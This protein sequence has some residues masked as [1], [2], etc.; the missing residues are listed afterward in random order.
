MFCLNI[1]REQCQTPSP[2]Y[3]HQTAELERLPDRPGLPLYLGPTTPL[4]LL[5]WIEC[6]DGT[7]QVTASAPGTIFMTLSDDLV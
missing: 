1:G 4:L 7:L 3:S 6:I 5:R 2:S